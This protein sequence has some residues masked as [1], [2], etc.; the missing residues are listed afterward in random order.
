MQAHIPS[1]LSEFSNPIMEKARLERGQREPV[2]A[3]TVSRMLGAPPAL[4]PATAPV[5][6][7]RV[8]PVK[9]CE[10]DANSPPTPPAAA[11][12]V[13]LD[14]V[15]Q[16]RRLEPVTTSETRSADEVDADEDEDGDEVGS[17]DSDNED[18]GLSDQDS[19]SEYDY[20]D[21]EGVVYESG[22]L[23]DTAN[24]AARLQAKTQKKEAKKLAKEAKALRRQ[25]KIPKHVK[26]RAVKTGKK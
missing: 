12:A 5:T 22:R 3:A 1:S 6:A 8:L 13:G 19:D 10:S 26:K 20:E 17:K 16:R 11:A 9:P 7:A 18:E 2:Y 21:E 14:R 24:A 23:P 25:T 4:S 15:P